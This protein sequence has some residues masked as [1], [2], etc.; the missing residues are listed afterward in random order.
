MSIFIFTLNYA[1]ITRR[2][3]YACMYASVHMNWSNKQS[4]HQGVEV[5]PPMGFGGPGGDCIDVASWFTW[6]RCHVERRP[7]LT[8]RASCFVPWNCNMERLGH[9]TLSPRG[10]LFF[11]YSLY[12]R[13]V[14]FLYLSQIFSYRKHY[15]NLLSLIFF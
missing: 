13:E 7:V 2:E 9:A 3:K 15:L 11:G 4:G 8:V 14:L 6:I 10:A 5:G 12:F 1:D